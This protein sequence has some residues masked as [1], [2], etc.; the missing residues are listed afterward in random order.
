VDQTMTV[1]IWYETAD[2][3]NSVERDD[4][5]DDKDG[6]VITYDE[7]PEPG[8]TRKVSFPIERVVRIDD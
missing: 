7:T 1:Q 2:G 3:L 8:V 4:W 5:H 6:F